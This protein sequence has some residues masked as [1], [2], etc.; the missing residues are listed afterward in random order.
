MHLR[1]ATY[2]LD[3]HINGTEKIFAQPGSTTLVP[4]IS[5]VDVA[6]GFW[7]NN[8]SSGHIGCEPFV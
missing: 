7:R 5:L 1:L 4:I 3:A 8:K 2:R 6:C